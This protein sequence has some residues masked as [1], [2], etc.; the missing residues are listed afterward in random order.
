MVAEQTQFQ[1]LERA[2]HHQKQREN[3]VNACPNPLAPLL[4]S[5]SLNLGNMW[6]VPS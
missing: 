2:G 5:L 4:Y 1:E 3:V 6:P